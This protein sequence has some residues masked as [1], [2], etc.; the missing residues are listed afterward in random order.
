MC[1]E[2]INQVAN[3]IEHYR[4]NLVYMLLCVN[5]CRCSNTNIG[6]KEVTG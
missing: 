2:R 4:D 5:M 6:I 1:S 3:L